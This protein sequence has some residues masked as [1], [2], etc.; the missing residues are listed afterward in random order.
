MALL[1]AMSWRLPVIAT[2]VGG[3][4]QLV[5]D[6]ANGL[7][8]SPGDIEGLA[9]TLAAVLED[10]ALRRRLGSAARATIEERFCLE[11]SLEQLGRIYA[12]FGMTARAQHAGT[13]GD[14]R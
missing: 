9:T 6:Q 8:V 13:S 14:L 7:L 3:V 11:R 12:R 2:P 1:E 10:G 4:P 5:Q